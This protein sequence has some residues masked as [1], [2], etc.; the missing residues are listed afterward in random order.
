MKRSISSGSTPFFKF[1]LSPAI[2]FFLLF[3]WINIGS[4]SDASTFFPLLVASLAAPV[5]LMPFIK[6]KRIYIDKDFLFVTNFLKGIVIP[7]SE[8]ESVRRVPNSSLVLEINLRHSSEFGK[9][10]LFLPRYGEAHE[11]RSVVEELE[12]R[13]TSQ[14]K[15]LGIE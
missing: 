4:L 1:F 14:R 12:K 11:R 15:R 5:F 2:I 10:I 8:V 7:I 6:L 3:L 9:R 13:A